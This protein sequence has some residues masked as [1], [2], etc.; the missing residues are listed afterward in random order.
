MAAAQLGAQSP[1]PP[2]AF[3][4]ATVKPSLSGDGVRGSCHGIDT[5]YA[6]GSEIVPPPLGRG[7]FTAARLGH[8]ID[9]A[10]GI[11][12]MRW[13]RGGPDWVLSGDD[14]FN[15]EGKAEDPAKTT[16]AQL[17][18]MLQTLLIERFQLKFHLEEA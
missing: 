13:I 1:A 9:I 4:V 5:T 7:V 10:F 6:P 16:S 17:L 12:N 15:I 11:H 8:L 3:E 14:R 2:P 18:A